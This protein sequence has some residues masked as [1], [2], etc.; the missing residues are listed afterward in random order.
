MMFKLPELAVAADALAAV[1]AIAAG[2]AR[3]E[4]NEAEARSLVGLV[5][6]FGQTLSVIDHEARLAE[7]EGQLRRRQP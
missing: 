3:G 2:V 1:S 7:I 5:E 4:L 6:C